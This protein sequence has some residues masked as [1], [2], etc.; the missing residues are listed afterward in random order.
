MAGH[1]GATTFVVAA[2]GVV[3]GLRVGVMSYS[4]LEQAIKLA[5]DSAAN[6]RRTRP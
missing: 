4:E 3:D 6:R 2:D 1:G 5:Q